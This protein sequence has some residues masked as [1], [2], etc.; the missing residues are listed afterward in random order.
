L[1][2]AYGL[3]PSTELLKMARK[4]GL[5]VPLEVEFFPLSAEERCRLPVTARNQ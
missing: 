2:R 5:D 1:R 4:R 3:D